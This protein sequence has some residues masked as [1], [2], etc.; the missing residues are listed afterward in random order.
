MLRYGRKMTKYLLNRAMRRLRLL[1]WTHND[2]MLT[3]RQHKAVRQ[4]H[5]KLLSKQGQLK[6]AIQ[7]GLDDSRQDDTANLAVKKR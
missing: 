3:T 2:D 1:R 7:A 6:A 4:L 5:R